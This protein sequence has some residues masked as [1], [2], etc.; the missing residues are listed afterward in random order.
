MEHIYKETQGMEKIVNFDMQ[1]GKYI[2]DQ[3]TN[4]L[5]SI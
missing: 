3:E 2:G 5:I 1:K 4:Y